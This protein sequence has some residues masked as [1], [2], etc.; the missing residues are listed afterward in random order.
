VDAAG[1]LGTVAVERVKLADDLAAVDVCG[2]AGANTE[3][4]NYSHVGAY[5]P[6]EQRN[7]VD[8]A[9][10]VWS[11]WSSW[12]RGFFWWDWP[13]AP[14]AATDTDY[15]PRGK[16]A[17]DLLRAWQSPP[18]SRNAVTNAASY[19]TDSVAPGAIVSVFGANLSAGTAQFTSFPLSTTLG[20]TS[21]TVNG[22]PA[23]L[24]F[25]S[26]QQ[27][28]AQA[29]F[30]VAAGSAIAEV[31]SSAGIALTQFT[32]GA[33]GPGI[34]T[35]NGLGTGDAAAIDAVSY[36]PVTASQP[37]A[38]GGYLGIY[39][40]GLGATQPAATTGAAPPNPPPQTSVQPTVLIDGQPAAPLWSG[41]APGFVGLNQVNVQVPATLAPGSHQ[42]QLTVSGATS[43]TVT[44]SVR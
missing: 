5:D 32:V 31:T 23:P 24:F 7:C 44:F 29:P 27:V 43:N 34:F 35:Q 38:A 9:F 12:M 30:E 28:N 3:P 4:W 21:V 20:D 8:A 14:P 6:T 25:A 16:P 40:T 33:A 18:D 37:I 39:C 17:A 42:L 26:P 13:V 41:L 22:T 2:Q 19:R 36:A 10:T 11:Q 1:H 15:N